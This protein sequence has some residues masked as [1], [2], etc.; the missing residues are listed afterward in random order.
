M[1]TFRNVVSHYPTLLKFLFAKK[2][3]KEKCVS[4][5]I[6]PILTIGKSRSIILIPIDY[7]ISKHV[8]QFFTIENCITFLHDSMCLSLFYRVNRIIFITK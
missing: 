7:I 3:K 8:L 4:R 2:Y 5:T 1:L 6:I